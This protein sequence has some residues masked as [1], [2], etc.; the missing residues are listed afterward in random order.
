LNCKNAGE[1]LEKVKP[2]NI[3]KELVLEAYKRVKAN[4]G[5]AGVD[6][7]SLEE[8]EISLDNNLYMLWN[9]MA[10]G[11]YFPPAVKAVAIPKRSG[12][13]RTLGIPTVT[14][15]I[16]QAVVKMVIEPNME[17]Y[18]HEDS[19][20]YRPNKQALDGVGATRKR[21]WEYAWLVEYDIKG[22]FDN[23]N[24][25]KLMKAVRGHAKEKWTLLYIERWLKVPIQHKKR[26]EQRTRGTPQ[27]GVISPLLSNLY[28][29]YTVDEWMRR[30]RP[31]IPWARYADD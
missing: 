28:M 31:E 9:R 26:L 8:F 3:S 18:F 13:K 5:A 14:D 2:F 20:G 4:K 29:H 7:Q 1:T 21:C 30:N 17:K 19:Y 16:A 22:L 24:H 23:I 10:S 27:G 11:S 6:D 25:E 15:R 12:G